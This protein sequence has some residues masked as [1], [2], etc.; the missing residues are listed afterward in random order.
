MKIC[1]FQPL[2]NRP[3]FPLLMAASALALML[4]ACS[5]DPPRKTAEDIA[6]MLDA[7]QVDAARHHAIL[8][9]EDEDQI[10]AAQLLLAAAMLEKNDEQGALLAISKARKA[11]ATS[12][13]VAHLEAEARAIQRKFDAVETL[14]ANP[15]GPHKAD[16]LRVR[17]YARMV[18]GQYSKGVQ[19]LADA[20]RLDP[21]NRRVLI[22]LASMH[23]DNGRYP[24]ALRVAR[25]LTKR[26]PRLTTGLV[27]EAKI[28]LAMDDLPAADRAFA[29]AL[30]RDPNKP[31]LIFARAD[32]LKKLGRIKAAS[33]MLQRGLKLDSENEAGLLLAVPVMRRTGQYDQAE[34][35]YSMLES[36]DKLNPPIMLEGA[37]LALARGLPNIARYRVSQA[38]FAD[39]RLGAAS[40]FLAELEWKD[41]DKERA[42]ELVAQMDKQ[43][44]NSAGLAKLK[45]AMGMSDTDGTTD[46]ALADPVLR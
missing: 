25:R 27:L 34:E 45:S 3:A 19:D 9:S 44:Y 42:R 30:K 46:A 11:G 2:M 31:D 33:Q 26:F 40:L 29:R 15:S 20:V 43:G 37:R 22:D 17:A 18:N 41:G 16:L 38:L 10:R 14:T 8:L 1:D 36:R 32:V 5:S 23:F 39:P 4:G 35:A 24:E 6:A 13:D 21:D 7:G 28:A 12:R